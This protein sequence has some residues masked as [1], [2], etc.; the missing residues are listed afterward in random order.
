MRRRLPS[1][2]RDLA[3]FQGEA[4]GLPLLMLTTATIIGG[5]VALLLWL[6]GPLG[7]PERRTGVVTAVGFVEQDEG[8]RATITAQVDG[9]VVR[10]V[11]P[12]VRNCRVGDRIVLSAR[13]GRRNYVY[14]TLGVANPCTRAPF[15]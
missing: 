4:L 13:K 10:L 5:L 8:S 2:L 11:M 9:Q 15:S 12:G 1:R 7:A 6:R 14:S 3:H